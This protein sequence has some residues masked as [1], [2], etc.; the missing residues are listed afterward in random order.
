MSIAASAVDVTSDG[1]QG[2]N[3]IQLN[4]DQQS[5]SNSNEL[6]YVD[7]NIN[8]EPGSVNC[9]RTFG[10]YDTGAEIS[11]IHPS[12]LQHLSNVEIVGQTQ[13]C[14]VFGDSVN[15]DLVKLSVS[16]NEGDRCDKFLNILCASTDQTRHELIL[17]ADVVDRLMTA[18][19]DKCDCD[20]CID[21]NAPAVTEVECVNNN[22]TACHNMSEVS[23]ENDCG[24]HIT[25]VTSNDAILTNSV[26]T[27]SQNMDQ[28]LND[29]NTNDVSECFDCID[30][31]NDVSVSRA[32]R[33]E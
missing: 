23:C 17:A 20:E 19:V 25:R 31:E 14:G 29:T 28:S 7:V 18:E 30:S 8:S 4:A 2:I 15:A 26:V 6:R 1:I 5:L 22:I 16:L 12:M 11:L 10:L 9:K 21:I 24:I 27:R 32:T 33:Q 3:L 13:L